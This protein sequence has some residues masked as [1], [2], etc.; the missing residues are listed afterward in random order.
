MNILDLDL[1]PRSRGQ[2]AAIDLRA[3]CMHRHLRGE[4]PFQRFAEPIAA[5]DLPDEEPCP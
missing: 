5:L 2:A 3:R 4:K 1:D